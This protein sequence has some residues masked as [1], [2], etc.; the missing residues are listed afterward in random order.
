MSD[1][2][3]VTAYV[4]EAVFFLV[5]I[6]ELPVHERGKRLGSVGKRSVLL[7]SRGRVVVC[8]RGFRAGF[9]QWF[10]ETRAD[11]NVTD[12]TVEN[13]QSRQDQRVVGQILAFPLR[14]IG[15]FITGVAV[16]GIRDFDFDSE[17]F[18]KKSRANSVKELMFSGFLSSPQSA[19]S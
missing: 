3:S 18:L 6:S 10:A 9:G 13:F 11:S 4:Y 19:E 16:R 17:C 1:H 5:F 15:A 2:G 12:L 14:T 8:R 7:C